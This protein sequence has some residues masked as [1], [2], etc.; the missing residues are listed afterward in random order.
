M[1]LPPRISGVL[2]ATKIARLSVL[3]GDEAASGDPARRAL[4]TTEQIRA[5]TGLDL[6]EMA[7][8]FGA[9]TADARAL[10]GA[11]GA[12]QTVPTSP[13]PLPARSRPARS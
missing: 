11:P 6:A 4:T 8:R 13:P 2:R 10:P 12:P 3:P 5:A 1:P 7:S 9:Q